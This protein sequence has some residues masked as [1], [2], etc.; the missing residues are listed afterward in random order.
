MIV[1]GLAVKQSGRPKVACVLLSGDTDQASLVDSFDL[2]A[3]SDTLINQIDLLGKALASKLSA[4]E[5]DNVVIKNADFAAVSSRKPGVAARLLLEG[6][7]AF[8]ARSRVPLVELR[9]GK[10]IGVKLGVS[11]EKALQRGSEIDAQRGEA[12][13]AA[14]SGLAGAV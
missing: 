4:L 6:A 12:A 13:A 11:K 5:V 9:N 8:A 3:N 2:T 10:D 14:L 1:L 7:L